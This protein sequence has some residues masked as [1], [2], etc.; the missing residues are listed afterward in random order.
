VVGLYKGSRAGPRR[1]RTA[2]RVASVGDAAQSGDVVMILLPIR[3]SARSSRRRSRAGWQGQDAACSPTAS[4]S[5]S[6]RSSPSAGRDVTM[7]APRR[8]PRH[9]RPSSPRARACP[10]LV[11]VHQTSPARHATWRS[12]Y[13][14]GVAARVPA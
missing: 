1:R 5:T 2:L 8:R 4:T 3:A 6:I 12:P 9:A 7:I 11:A 13:G 14:K 10:R